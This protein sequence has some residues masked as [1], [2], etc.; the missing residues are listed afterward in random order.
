MDMWGAAVCAL[1]TI[2]WMPLLVQSGMNLYLGS[3]IVLHELCLPFLL[4]NSLKNSVMINWTQ[5]LL[6][7]ASIKKTDAITLCTPYCTPCGLGSVVGITTGYGMDGPGIESRWVRDFRHLSRLA[8]GPTQP[9]VQWVLSLSR[10]KQLP[11]HDA[12]PSP[13]SS[14]VVKKG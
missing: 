8:L 14:A 6:F 2:C 1:I 3:G 9:H 13:P 10:G 11:R 12:D 7:I 4:F 5:W